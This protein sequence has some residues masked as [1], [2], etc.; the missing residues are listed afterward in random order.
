MS[1]TSPKNQDTIQANQ[2][3]TVTMAIKNMEVP[4]FLSSVSR[5]NKIDSLD[6]SLQTGNFVNADANY[7]SA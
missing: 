1:A 3:F 2:N 5:T 6:S 7:F 4:L